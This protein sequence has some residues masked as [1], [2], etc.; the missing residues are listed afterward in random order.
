MKINEFRSMSKEALY[1]KYNE[2]KKELMGIRFAGALGDSSP[3]TAKIKFLR[4]SIARIK[5][6]YN[7]KN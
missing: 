6:V 3:N 7:S 4:R 1:D 5:T 2:L